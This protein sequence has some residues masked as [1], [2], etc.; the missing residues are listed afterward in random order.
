MVCTVMPSSLGTF[1]KVVILVILRPSFSEDTL[2]KLLMARL[3]EPARHGL[4][5]VWFV[6]IGNVLRNY[7]KNVS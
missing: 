3:E 7:I 2:V 5:Q 6:N 4:V 1:L